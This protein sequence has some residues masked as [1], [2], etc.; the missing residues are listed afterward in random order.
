[1][2]RTIPRTNAGFTLLE[3]AIAMAL[4]MVVLGVVAQGLISYYVVMDAQHQ[5]AAAAEILRGAVA[6]IRAERDA[7]PGAFPN[8]VTDVFPDGDTMAGPGLLPN[9]SIVVSYADDGANPLEVAVTVTWTDLH[10]RPL[11]ETISTM[12]TDR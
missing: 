11:Q 5:R 7:N 1:M 8:A 10:G 9:E 2:L 3:V 12:L 6:Q 4:F